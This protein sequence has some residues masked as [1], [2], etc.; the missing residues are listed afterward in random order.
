MCLTRSPM[1][2]PNAMYATFFIA[3]GIRCEDITDSEETSAA[4]TQIMI[5]RILIR[6]ISNA[7]V[8]VY[9]PLIRL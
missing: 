2:D 1:L 7:D 3:D 4:E 8:R 5:P 9:L 6:E